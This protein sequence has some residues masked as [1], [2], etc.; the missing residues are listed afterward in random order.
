MFRRLIGTEIWHSSPECEFW[1]TQ[2]FEDKETPTIGHRC[3]TCRRIEAAK[4]AESAAQSKP[5]D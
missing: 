4:D 3:V 5:R 2:D 1:P